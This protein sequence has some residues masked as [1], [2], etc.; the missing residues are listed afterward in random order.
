[1]IFEFIYCLIEDIKRFL[2]RLVVD[3]DCKKCQGSNGHCN[4]CK[5]G[6]DLYD[7][8]TNKRDKD[9]YKTDWDKVYAMH[10]TRKQKRF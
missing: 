8:S 5:W 3:V 1:M 9:L 4:E 7:H 10:R 2:I 6:K